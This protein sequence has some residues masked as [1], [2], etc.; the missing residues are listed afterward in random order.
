MIWGVRYHCGK[1]YIFLVII[2]GGLKMNEYKVLEAYE[3]AARGEYFLV[4]MVYSHVFCLSEIK[5]AS[6]RTQPMFVAQDRARHV[7]GLIANPP[8]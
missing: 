7:G 1:G 6:C 5:I 2:L 8:S 4:A 3:G